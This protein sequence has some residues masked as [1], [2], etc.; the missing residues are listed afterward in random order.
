MNK[1]ENNLKAR[2]PARG[3]YRSPST[4]E[5]DF[6]EDTTYQLRWRVGTLRLHCKGRLNRIWGLMRWVCQEGLEKEEK[7]GD[8]GT[9]GQSHDGIRCTIQL[10]LVY[11]YMLGKKSL[12]HPVLC[13]FW[14]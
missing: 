8:F 9:Q 1:G 3:Y 5:E 10:H 7:D 13:V 2:E 14:L 12:Y 6:H 11:S 4:R